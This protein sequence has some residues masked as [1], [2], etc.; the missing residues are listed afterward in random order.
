MP[1]ASA[2]DL[3]EE[4]RNHAQGLG[5]A[6]CAF[7]S[8]QPLVDD[9]R[10]DNWLTEGR[11]ASMTW[12]ARDPARRLNPQRALTTAK[13]V[14]MV[15]WP[16]ALADPGGTPEAEELRGRIAAYAIGPDYHDVLSE[17]LQRLA[18]LIKES[19]GAQ[20]TIYVDGGP[21]LEKAFA[22][23]AGLGWFGHNTNLLNRSLGSAFLLGSLITEA[24]IA[25]D[26]PF[27]TDHCGT[28][29][30]CQP[31]CPTAALGENRS[32]DAGK[33]ISYLT[34]EH[35]GPVPEPLRSPMGEWIF[36]CDLCQ[37]VCPWSPDKR[38]VDGRLWP[39]LAPILELSRAQ[40]RER[41]AGTAVLRAK[42]RGLARNAAVALGNSGQA[43]AVDPLARALLEHD[44][45]LVRS[46]A[47][48]ALGELSRRQSATL[49]G[50]R[51][52]ALA[53]ARALETEVAWP[54][55]EEVTI[56]MARL[57]Q[58]SPR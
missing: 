33:C 20:S 46:H 22:S 19:T 36:G 52:S 48:W 32:I 8:A 35:R 5:F 6:A 24:E 38:S 58:E 26:P 44:E 30:A 31:A 29:R 27:E 13:T 7:T 39:S 43:A 4:V 56:A 49:G 12:M 47:A 42:R 15:A 50:S 16:Y 18:A 37:D 54:V 10:L 53:L 51:A 28:C 1:N 25:A 21:L 3:A 34:I 2:I 14:I 41:F 11:H 57:D 17:R 55:R 40:F 23:K 45:A 9:K